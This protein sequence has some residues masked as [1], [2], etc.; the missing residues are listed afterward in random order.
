MAIHVVSRGFGVGIA[1]G[2][3][4]TDQSNGFSS[5]DE[6]SQREPPPVLEAYCSASWT[7]LFSDESFRHPANA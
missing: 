7:S 2:V 6:V 5:G 1:H 3:F 4:S